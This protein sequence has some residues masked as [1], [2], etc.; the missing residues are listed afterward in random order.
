MRKFFSLFA[1]HMGS[2]G[3]G[4]VAVGLLLFVWSVFTN[5]PN[6]KDNMLIG[7]LVAVLAGVFLIY[8]GIKREGGY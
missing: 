7:G 3:V 4:A 8:K 6:A 2:I 1:R 5:S